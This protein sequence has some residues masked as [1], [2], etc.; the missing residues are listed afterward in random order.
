MF[1]VRSPSGDAYDVMVSWPEG[2][3][4]PEG[5]PALW[6]L[7]GE[8]NF[9][10]AT[11]TARRL[12]RARARSGVEPGV[13]IAIAAGTLQRR[14]R[15]YTPAVPGYSIPVGTPGHGLPTGGADAFLAFVENAIR[16]AV[17]ARW[18]IDP[19]R[20]TL[21]GHSFGGVLAGHALI[22]GGAF[23]RYA[24]ISPSLWYGGEAS[25]LDAAKDLAGKSI[26]L[27]EATATDKSDP[28]ILAYAAQ[29]ERHHAA[30]R[31]LPLPGHDH[32][33]TMPAAMTRIIAFAFSQ[34]TQS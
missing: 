4:P 7:D 27:A 14:A 20:Q 24:L 11:A 17:N 22:S 1:T 23:T 8:D 9:A 16:P 19:A 15:D 21:A 28:R 18:K 29:L 34:E 26:L 13:I 33:S 5:W 32:G 2:S 12:E 6:L 30:V 25:P 3:A 31:I 10:F